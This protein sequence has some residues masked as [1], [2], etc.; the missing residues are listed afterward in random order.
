MKRCGKCGMEKDEGEF[1]RRKRSGDGLQHWCKVCRRAYDHAYN[2]D[3]RRDP[4]HPAHLSRLRRSLAGSQRASRLKK[5][6]EHSYTWTGREA[7]WRQRRIECIPGCVANGGFLCRTHYQ[8]LW[9]YQGGRCA[10]CGGLLARGMKPYP[11][12]DHYH[13]DPDGRGPIRGLLHGGKTGCNI[14]ILGAFEAGRKVPD[15]ALEI[16]CRAYLDNP[17]SSRMVGSSWSRTPQPVP[18]Y[19]GSEV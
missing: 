19:L 1:G 17:P 16:A 5:D 12:A 8:T 3:A 10:L 9:D 14:R 11:A 18:K 13:R 4:N 6:P 15:E 2:R 7:N